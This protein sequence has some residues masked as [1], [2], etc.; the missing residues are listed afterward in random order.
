VSAARIVADLDEEVY[1][2]DPAL[3]SSGARAILKSPAKFAHARE[4][5]Q[6]RKA[7]FD[8]GHAAH[9]LVL[10]V[11][12]PLVVVEADSWRTNAAQRQRDEAY[13][14]GA[15]PLLRGDFATV[16][17]MAAAL[18][19]HPTAH[20]LL[21]G[22]GAAEL[23]GFWTDEATGVACRSRFDWLREAP[24]GA[25]IVDYKSTGDAGPRGFAKSVAEF[26]YHQQDAWY[27]AAAAALGLG[28]LPFVFIAQEKTP[29]YLVACYELDDAAV[30]AGGRRNRAAVELFAECTETGVWPGYAPGIT[31]LGLPP[32]AVRDYTE[33]YL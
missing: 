2:E 17:E 29:P 3:S 20:R 30:N 22:S 23:S 21:Y 24:D 15:V 16:T 4:H 25:A 26:G 9:A 27:R 10:G 31:L 19:G 32:W 12:Q 28:D 13:E 7:A 14:V 1:H 8:F 6:P 33:E 18:R 11:G 5:G